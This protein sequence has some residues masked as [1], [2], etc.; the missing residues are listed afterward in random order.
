MNNIVPISPDGKFHDLDDFVVDEVNTTIFLSIVSDV[1]K[2]PIIDA[3][4]IDNQFNA[5]RT[6]K[7]DSDY[8][9]FRETVHFKG[10]INESQERIKGS[11]LVEQYFDQRL[12]YQY[13][14]QFD[15]NQLMRAAHDDRIEFIGVSKGFKKNRAWSD[16][17]PS[18]GGVKVLV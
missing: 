13:K 16:I 14:V 2:G 6:K 11:I 12:V 15:S 8:L 5:F 17:N 9:G 3:D 7:G 4:I 1:I 10:N 18:N